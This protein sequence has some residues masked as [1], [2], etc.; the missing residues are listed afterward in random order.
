MLEFDYIEG[1]NNLK[2]WI[3][4]YNVYDELDLWNLKEYNSEAEIFRVKE[5]VWDILTDRV[6]WVK[7][8]DNGPVE[9]AL[10]EELTP[11]I[12]DIFSHVFEDIFEIRVKEYICLGRRIMLYELIRGLVMKLTN[13]SIPKDVYQERGN[14]KDPPHVEEWT[15][16]NNLGIKG[17]SSSIHCGTKRM[18]RI[19]IH[20]YPYGGEV[21]ALN[22]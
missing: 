14:C 5:R 16:Q 17:Y 4:L 3:L 11:E 9:V 6:D 18:R 10:D 2:N 8:T 13:T 12:L 7:Q 1:T 19:E 21:W 22:P 20:P 15:C